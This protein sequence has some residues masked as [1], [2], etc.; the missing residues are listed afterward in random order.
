MFVRID[1]SDHRMCLHL[2]RTICG[3]E[4]RTTMTDAHIGDLC[5]LNVVE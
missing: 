2:H 4:H 3:Y 1:S 5:K